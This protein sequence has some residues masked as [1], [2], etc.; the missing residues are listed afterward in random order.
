MQTKQEK[1]EALKDAAVDR[2][3]ESLRGK[4]EVTSLQRHKDETDRELSAAK[5]ALKE[6]Q[7]ELDK[8]QGLARGLQKEKEL[9]KV[10]MRA[11][12]RKTFGMADVASRENL[13]SRRSC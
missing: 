2:E 3:T 13:H 12:D 10:R 8:A 7:E 5:T 9:F 4:Q 6:L 11:N 1:I